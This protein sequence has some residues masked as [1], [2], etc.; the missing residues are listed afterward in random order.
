MGA[1]KVGGFQPE[2]TVRTEMLIL[3]KTTIAYRRPGYPGLE[4]EANVQTGRA[5]DPV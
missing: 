4:Y 1:A 5:P 2:I 3:G